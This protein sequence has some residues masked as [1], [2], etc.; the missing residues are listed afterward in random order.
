MFTFGLV[1]N[2]YT[3]FRL[4]ITLKICTSYPGWQA[5][6]SREASWEG[7]QRGRALCAQAGS[8]SRG[9]AACS[10]SQQHFTQ[11]LTNAIG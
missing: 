7:V 2:N 8:A 6:A 3:G 11:T 10:A 4:C 9:L 5:A 1:Q